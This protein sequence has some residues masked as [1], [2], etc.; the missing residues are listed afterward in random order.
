[1]W[2]LVAQKIV[3]LHDLETHWSLEDVLK[4]C[5]ILEFKE[6]IANERRKKAANVNRKITPH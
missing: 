1:M 3:T 5:A 6:D 2:S 4:V